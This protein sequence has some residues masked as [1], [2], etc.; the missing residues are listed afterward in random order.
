MEDFLMS[1]EDHENL[2]NELLDAGLEQT[3]RTEILQ[4]LRVSHAKTTDG[5]AKVLE[6]NT[7][8][9]TDNTDLVTANS[10]LFRE[11]GIVGANAEEQQKL[12]EKD[13]SETITIEDIL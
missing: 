4:Q 11:L 10:K 12:E 1:Q 8:L 2:L 3:R 5:V 13:H 7:K 9:Q 6:T